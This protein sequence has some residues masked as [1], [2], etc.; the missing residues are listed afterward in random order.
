MERMLLTDFL[1]HV[2]DGSGIGSVSH[3]IEGVYRV[4]RPPD[5][6][7]IPTVSPVEGP[8][9]PPD[10]RGLVLLSASA[11]VG[12][13]AAAAYIA[14]T[15]HGLLMDLAQLQVGHGTVAGTLVN[16]LGASEGS[17]FFER[18]GQGKDLLVL[19]ALDE[20]QIRSGERNFQAF[21]NDIVRF[22]RDHVGP[23][24][25]L[26]LARNETAEWIH[27]NFAD[28]GVGLPW[29]AVDF[30]DQPRALEFIE[31]RLDATSERHGTPPHRQHYDAFCEAREALFRLIVETVYTP[32]AAE[33][34][35]P[36]LQQFLGYA[37]VLE[38]LTQYLRTANYGKLVVEISSWRTHGGYSGSQW[39]LLRELVEKILDREQDK[40]S[41]QVWNQMAPYLL[42]SAT[43]KAAFY[44]PDEQCARLLAVMR[45]EVPLPQ[46]PASLPEEVR[47]AYEEAARTAISNHPFLLDQREFVNVVF[48]DYVFAK[49]LHDRIAPPRALT[50]V[51]VIM[52]GVGY[53]ESPLFAAFFSS[54]SPNTSL[55]VAAEDVG[56]IYESASSYQTPENPVLLYVAA[57][58]EK[59]LG[60]LGEIKRK[61]PALVFTIDH[62][63]EGISFPSRLRHAVVAVET[64]VDL[65]GRG[66]NFVLGPD[67][68]LAARELTIS[69]KQLSINTNTTSSVD[70]V[71]M[72]YED[73][74]DLE[75]RIIGAGSVGA[76]LPEKRFPW[77]GKVEDVD[78]VLAGPAQNEF[79]EFRRIIMRFR[80]G[81]SGSLNV[82]RDLMDN[83]V[84]QGNPTASAIMLQLV[85]EGVVDIERDFYR[86]GAQA[87]QEFG[88][89]YVDIRQGRF[90]DNVSAF[91]ARAKKRK[92]ADS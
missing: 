79:A 25:I 2:A 80:G 38:V 60:M 85:E 42:N 71:A 63:E 66:E 7:I 45:V 8:F 5:A 50:A 58:E 29:V 9:P 73:S 48:R 76:S 54:L 78:F 68:L 37:P 61:E 13:S 15:R 62:L 11:A 56:L 47:G 92:S 12:K 88:L 40:F 21:L 52:R 69:A 4:A 70:L 74:G 22:A 18:L 64:L 1:D 32:D 67:V 46:L 35:T 57:N 59:T 89:S 20:T 51:R 17:A 3:D 23:P 16:A 87:M 30:F 77:A 10:P 26:L 81:Q 44:T 49:T 84:L 36:E 72:Q 41:N 31:R 91:L 24:S 82:Y 53:R 65:G 19:D 34:W 28:E 55:V 39:R 27:L 43:G 86:I 33:T 14:A 83:F 75:L 6:Y 90:N